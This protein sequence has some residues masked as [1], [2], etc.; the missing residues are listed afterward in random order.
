METIKRSRIAF[1]PHSPQPP[2]RIQPSVKAPVKRSIVIVDDEKIYAELMAKTMGENLD[3]P[4]H[5]FTRPLDAL[6]AVGTLVVG[7]VEHGLRPVPGRQQLGQ[8]GL[9]A[10]GARLVRPFVQPVASAAVAQFARS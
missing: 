8:K 3:C 9:F 7:V 10:I 6:A 4:V 5:A 1:Q 2:V